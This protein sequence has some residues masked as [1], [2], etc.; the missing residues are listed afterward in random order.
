MSKKRPHSHTPFSLGRVFWQS[1]RAHSSKVVSSPL[2]HQQ[3]VKLVVVTVEKVQ[4]LSQSRTNESTSL[5]NCLSHLSYLYLPFVHLPFVPYS[6]HTNLPYK[7]FSPV[8]TIALTN[9]F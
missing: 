3:Q 6:I 8:S 2:A 9:G 7:H 4:V 1:F 5:A